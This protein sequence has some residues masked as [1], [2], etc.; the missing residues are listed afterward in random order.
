MTISIILTAG[1]AGSGTEYVG[2]VFF[3]T[4][5]GMVRMSQTV[6]HSSANIFTFFGICNENERMIYNTNGIVQHRR[7]IA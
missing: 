7:Y 5:V 3:L 4:M 1:S 2:K 6:A